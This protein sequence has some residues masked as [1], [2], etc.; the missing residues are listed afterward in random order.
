MSDEIVGGH[1]IRA[2]RGRA[3]TDRHLHSLQFRAALGYPCAKSRCNVDGG[4]S[5][6]VRKHDEK[7]VPSV[8]AQSILR[9]QRGL[10]AFRGCGQ[11]SVSFE[12][13]MLVVD[14][15]E[16]I[17]I[18]HE[19]GQ[20]RPSAFRSTDLSLEILRHGATTQGAREVVMSRDLAEIVVCPQ[21][22][23]LQLVDSSSGL[24]PGSEF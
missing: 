6:T 17:E 16:P 21:E 12:V 19:N 23:F 18:Q 3:N 5:V 8:A 9:A 10:H 24:Q 14:S 15:L 22:M 20:R 7:F 11:H 13:A 1:T 2:T 4:R